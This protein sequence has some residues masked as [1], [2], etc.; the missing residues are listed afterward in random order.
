MFNGSGQLSDKSNV[1][2]L[3]QAFEESSYSHNKRVAALA[4]EIGRAAG[5]NGSS[6]E[7]LAEAALHYKLPPK[8]FG[9][10]FMSRLLE[11]A[12]GMKGPSGSP[13]TYVGDSAM[14]VLDGL[15]GHPVSPSAQKLAE[16]LEVAEAIDASVEWDSIDPSSDNET[17]FG[18]GLNILRR[19]DLDDLRHLTGRLPAFPASTVHELL[20]ITGEDASMLD[21]EKIGSRDPVIAGELVSA[22]NCALNGSRTDIRTLHAALNFIGVDHARAVIMAAMLRPMLR[23]RG[24]QH[25]W[26][27]SL[28][29]A[30]TAAAI[31]K[32][33]RSA[34]IAEAML[35]GLMHDIGC[36]ALAAVDAEA[37]NICE[38]LRSNGY[39]PSVAERLV[40]GFDHA[41]AGRELLKSWGFPDDIAI[42]IGSHH[43]PEEQTNNVLASL[44]YLV[45]FCTC[46]EEDL[47]SNYRLKVALEVVGITLEEVIRLKEGRSL[48]KLN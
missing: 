17:F 39:P 3:Q 33:V 10:A 18:T 43:R 4:R 25:L 32:K 9:S 2:V 46:S 29:A 15:A 8:I 26:T 34:S 40:C 13:P 12:V 47:P 14:E 22:A 31:A 5:V 7:V 30:D 38:R 42:G 21:F 28:H 45:E 24:T 36:V 20:R 1:Q 35:A 27:H 11:D 6:L 19:V 23:N 16:I 37:V 41:K 44:L 48:A